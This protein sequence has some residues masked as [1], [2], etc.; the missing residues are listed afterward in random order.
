MNRILIIGVGNTLRRDDG[1][2]HVLLTH[3]PYSDDVTVL[4]VPQ[5][6]PEHALEF[7]KYDVVVCVDAAV[8][9]AEVSI[10]VDSSSICQALPKRNAWGHVLKLEDIVT[11][12]QE[13]HGRCPALF[14]LAIPASDFSFG[15]GLT[16]KTQQAVETA[17]KVLMEFLSQ[18]AG[19]L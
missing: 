10:T 7:G 19:S 17:Q 11:L 15:E 14:R 18:R 8:D 16:E 13:L 2:A 1:A 9:V 5:W 6:F 3:Y 4:T 12:C